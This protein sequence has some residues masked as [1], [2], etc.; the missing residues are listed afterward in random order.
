M[1][2]PDDEGWGQSGP[3]P[4]ASDELDDDDTCFV[5]DALLPSSS[6]V[7]YDRRARACQHIL[8]AYT[9]EAP[10]YIRRSVA[11][12]NVRKILNK[13]IRLEWLAVL[14]LVC[15]SIY[16]RPVWCVEMQNKT[17]GTYPCET[18]EYPGWGHKFMSLQ[19]AFT[20]EFSCL[21]VLLLFLAGHIFAGTIR[22]AVRTSLACSAPNS[23]HAF[24]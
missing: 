2:L 22:P 23:T 7:S 10:V 19:R 4:L 9:T 24:S 17:H 13:L 20:W 5:E 21:A 6:G 8:A 15:L 12:R 11:A 14:L 16:E 18:S 3:R 1:S